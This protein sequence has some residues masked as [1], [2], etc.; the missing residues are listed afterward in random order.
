V[1]V[2]VVLQ[3]NHRTYKK[4]K[5]EDFGVTKTPAMEPKFIADT[6]AVIPSP[7]LYYSI[8]GLRLSVFGV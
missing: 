6:I 7:P 2:A 5:T 3:P 1:A 4:E 8:E